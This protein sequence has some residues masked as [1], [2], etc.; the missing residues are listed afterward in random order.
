[1]VETETLQ[2]H[3]QR[4]EEVVKNDKCNECDGLIAVAERAHRLKVPLTV[5]KHG[6]VTPKTL[7]RNLRKVNFNPNNRSGM[8]RY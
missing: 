1:M 4:N 8:C 6:P 5:N 2:K 3:Y 7:H